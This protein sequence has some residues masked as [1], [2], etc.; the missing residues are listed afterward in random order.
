MEIEPAIPTR[1]APRIQMGLNL[2]EPVVSNRNQ[3]SYVRSLTGNL[4]V[5]RSITARTGKPGFARAVTLV[6]ATAKIGVPLTQ[7]GGAE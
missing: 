4:T 2:F 3:T 1:F 7:Q 5:I 6:R